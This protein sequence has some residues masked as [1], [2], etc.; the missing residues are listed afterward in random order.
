MRG[1]VYVM[2]NKSMPGL[3]K[4]GFSTKDPSFRAQELC[5]TG[6]PHPFLVEY[7]AL[8]E[9]PRLVEQAVH[10]ELA[11]YHESKEFFRVAV[12]LAVQAIQHALHFQGKATLSE[13]SKYRGASCATSA[14]EAMRKATAFE[15]P[16]KTN[17]GFS[18]TTR[19]VGSCG[20]CGRKFGLTL[21]RH[22]C[23]AVCPHCFRRNDV[24]DYMQEAFAE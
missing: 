8:V 10:R 5:G 19:F 15:Q 22:D 7:D 24:S 18:R 23:G 9:G 21:T 1:W 14:D 13:T 17:A 11:R 4:V 6:H 16:T 3:V 12:E 2:T 20:Y